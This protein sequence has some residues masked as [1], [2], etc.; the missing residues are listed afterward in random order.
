MLDAA[1]AQEPLLDALL[2]GTDLQLSDKG[3][4]GKPLLYGA[5][6][7]PEVLQKLLKHGL[8]VN[9]ANPEDQT[10]PLIYALRNG[11]D[12]AVEL[13]LQVCSPCPIVNRLVGC[14]VTEHAGCVGG[15]AWPVSEG[16]WH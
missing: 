8:N 15:S 2:E 6:H 9:Q 12:E 10:T 3:P 7:M 13:L 5:L 16:R 11:L 14:D 4:G 1:A